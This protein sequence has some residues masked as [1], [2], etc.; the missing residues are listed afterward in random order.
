MIRRIAITLAA[1]LSILAATTVASA[2]EPP[3]V[4][5]TA[6][7][8]ATVTTSSP[9]V[10][11]AQTT[12]A[13]PT[14]AKVEDGTPDHEKVVG[15]LGV[16]YFN[17]SKL[18][19]AQGLGAGAPAPGTVNAPVVGVRYWLQRGLGIDAGLGFGLTGSSS[20][21]VQGGTTTTVDNPSAFGLAVHGGVPIALA[22]GKHYSFEVI[23]ELNVGFTSGTIK[24]N[25]P[26]VA[27]IDLSG[28]RFDLGARV[29]AEVYFGFIGIP[30]LALQA[31]VGL[32]FSRQAW[33]AKQ[34]DVSASS[35]TT[36]LGTTLNGEPW[37]IFTNS[38][39]A[40]YYF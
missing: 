15:H 6:S 16:S 19:I 26:N 1:G 8:S 33:K 21:R 9:P 24:A 11:T 40:I 37:A 25:Q 13:S 32:A 22:N 34:G 2:E 5:G 23:P 7:G 14:P 35:G 36:S 29:G 3:P 18:P 38:I 39:A 30:E 12:V 20:E 10:A 28:F 27:D 31:S 17:I 4:S